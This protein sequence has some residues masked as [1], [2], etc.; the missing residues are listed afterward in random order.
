MEKQ[1]PL[2]T[3]RE[4]AALTQ[5]EVSKATGVSTSRLSLAEN[6]LGTLTKDEEAKIRAAIVAK[7][8][9]RSGQVLRETDPRLRAAMAMI[10]SRPASKKLFAKGKESL[11]CG[12]EAAAVFVLGRRYPKGAV[13]PGDMS[14]KG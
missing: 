4:G 8:N 13:L 12:D 1:H 10:E 9:E 3:L 11:G 6:W 14:L 7:T 2:K 5:V